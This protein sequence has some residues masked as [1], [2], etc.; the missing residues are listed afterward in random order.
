MIEFI[1]G[2]VAELTPASVVLECYGIGYFLNI[3]LNTYSSLAQG[4]KAI[5]NAGYI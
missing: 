5:I 4:K 2:E 1:T 3:S